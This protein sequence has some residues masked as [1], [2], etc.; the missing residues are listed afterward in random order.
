MQRWET[1]HRVRRLSLSQLRLG[2]QVVEFALVLPIFLMLIFAGIEFFREPHSPQPRLSPPKLL[3]RLSLRHQ[4][5][6][7][8]KLPSRKQPSLLKINRR[9]QPRRAKRL[10]PQIKFR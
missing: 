7:R 6:L 3:K 4:K 8:Q 5:H 9:S 2:T 1:R 10:H